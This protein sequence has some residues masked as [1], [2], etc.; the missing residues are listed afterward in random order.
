MNLINF[1]KI[2]HI[3]IYKF[4]KIEKNKNYIKINKLKIFIIKKT[5]LLN[6]FSIIIIFYISGIMKHY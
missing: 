1:E 3:G 2:I 6:K 4:F 5:Y